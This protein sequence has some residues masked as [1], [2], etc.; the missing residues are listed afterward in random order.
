ME[1]KLG[2]K[3]LDLD[4]YYRKD[5]YRRFTKVA[6]SSVSITHTIDVTE[7]VEHSRKTGT[8][9]YINFL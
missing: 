1:Q 7:L 8:K 3:I 6:R 2:Y 4:N 9:F 5:I